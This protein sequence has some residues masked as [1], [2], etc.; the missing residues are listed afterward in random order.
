MRYAYTFAEAQE[1]CARIGASIAT[2]EQLYAAYLGGYEQCDAGWIADQTVRWAPQLPRHCAHGLAQSFPRESPALPCALLPQVPHP[3][4]P[5]GLL[6]RHEWLPW[7]EELW[8]GG[9][10]GHVRCVLLR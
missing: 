6:W 2:P 10:R 5:R 9:P 8:S 4:T 7:G 3:D 1:A